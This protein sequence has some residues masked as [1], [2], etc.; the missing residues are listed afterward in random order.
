MD[1][2]AT[3]VQPAASGD[4]PAIA[5][6]A[7]VYKTLLESTQAI[8][9]KIDWASMRFSYIGPQIATLLGWEQDSWRTVDD[10]AQRIHAD[11]REA[12]VNFCVAQSQAGVDHEADYRALTAAGSYI[13]IRD[14]VHV[15]RKADGTVDAL[16][17]FMFDISARK[18]TEEELARLRDELERLS[19]TD[20]LTGIANRRYFDQRLESEWNDSRRGRK[21]LSLILLDIDFFK[22]FND[23][24]GHVRGDECLRNV[25]GVLKS[26]ARRPHDVVARYGGEEF[27]VLLPETGDAMARTVAERCAEGIRDLRLAHPQ[28]TIGPFV[29]ASLGIATTIADIQAQPLGFVEAVDRMLYAAKRN[30]RNRIEASSLL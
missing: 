1:L 7:A 23:H 5:H 12:V 26:V 21:P 9:W 17:G 24:H 20:G 8:P 22:Q 28:S 16:V 13:W 29:T 18:K 11:D 15:V 25:A 3:R 30:G 10:W 14:V 27:I 4:P 2:P 6:D 19:M